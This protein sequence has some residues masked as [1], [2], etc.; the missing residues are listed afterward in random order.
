SLVLTFLVPLFMAFMSRETFHRINR[1]VLLA[2]MLLAFV[3]PAVNLGV[4]SPFARFA[5]IMQDSAVPTTAGT[6]VASTG[7][8]VG[9]LDVA[10]LGGAT[11]L[12]STASSGPFDWLLMAFVVYMSGVGVLL[13]RQVVVYMQMFRLLLAS[14]AVDASHYGAQGI[15]LRVHCG[16]EKP[17]SW[18]R[19]VVLGEDDMQDGAREILTHEA[20][21]VAAGHSWDIVFADAVIILQWFNPLAWIAKSVLKDIHEFEAD[22]AVINSGV[23]AKQYQLLIIKKAV[24]ARLYSIANSFN[25]SL[26]KKRITMMCKEK[27]K[28]WR[29][30]KALYILPV[31]AVAALSFS[32][33]ENANA[34]ETELASKVNEIAMNGASVSG[35]I[36]AGT[37]VI[38]E[39]AVAADTVVYQVCEQQPEFPGGGSA[40]VKF[41]A[42]NI[43]YPA[44]AMEAGKGGKVFVQFVVRRDGSVNDVVI[45]KSSGTPSLDNEALRVVKSM[46]KW[47]PGMQRGEAVN[48]RFM[49]PVAFA[50]QGKTTAPKKESVIT[51]E[52]GGMMV[53]EP[54]DFAV[55]VNG[56]FYE[57]DLKD[58]DSNTIE[59][60]TVVPVDKLTGDHL[61]KCRQLGK[62]GVLFIAIK[63]EEPAKEAVFMVCEQQPEFPGGQQALMKFLQ[64]NIRYPLAARNAQL[65]GK[66]YVQFVVKS[67]GTIVDVV[68]KKADYS[69]QGK[70]MQESTEELEKLFGE[71]SS[72][73]RLDDVVVVTYANGEEERLDT[74][75]PDKHP[76]AKFLAAEAVRVVSVMPNWTPGMQGGKPVNVQCMLPISFRLQ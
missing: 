52:G 18:F 9:E 5:A 57:G 61:N 17:F 71:G 47:K 41:L 69:F 36:S 59:S 70:L 22:E 75:A 74:A 76:A 65:Q 46:P 34:V 60:V 66:I 37:P 12:V 21:H 42:E 35:E 51:L 27:S 4:E 1:F 62:K 53:K 56:A 29:C 33:V 32:T 28:K 14:R 73:K 16:K 26:T 50:P 54:S 40:M 30:A 15:R 68:V 19:W 31:A 58:I 25:H 49:I 20:A 72:V 67:D 43:K 63:T 10:A 2:I 8:L 24:G 23:N 3:L 11:Q 39:T 44:D 48:V 7:V 38:P 55:V 45:M 13:V 64:T 6:D